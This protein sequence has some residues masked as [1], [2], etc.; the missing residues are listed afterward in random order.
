MTNSMIIPH[1]AESYNQVKAQCFSILSKDGVVRAYSFLDSQKEKLGY[2]EWVGLRAE[3]DFYV[4]Y[5]K[6]FTLD[7][8]WDFGIKADF[9]GNI[10]GCPNCR[11]DVTTNLDFKK[12]KTYEPLQVTEGRSYKIVVMNPQTRE[13]EDIFDLNFP[14][15]ATGKGREFDIALFYPGEHDERGGFINSPKQR[16]LRVGSSR[17]SVLF[18][19]FEVSTDFFFPDPTVYADYLDSV[20]DEDHFKKAMN[21]YYVYSARILSKSTGLNIVACGSPHISYLD[22]RTCEDE[23]YDTILLWRHPVIEDYLPDLL[24]IDLLGK[25]ENL[26]DEEVDEEE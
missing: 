12:L 18:D 8:L 24:D 9:T 25:E 10:D 4:G 22:P 23:L 26:S 5:R 11:I 1:P 6:E 19:V 17:P 15:D 13:I 16:I 20:V 3:M 7:P 21:D 14:F 2:K